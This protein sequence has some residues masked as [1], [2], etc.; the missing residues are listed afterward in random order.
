MTE[1]KNIYEALLAVYNEIGY[2]QKTG[3]N[4]AQNYRF[5][6]EAAFIEALRPVMIMNGIVCH[7]S[8]VRDTSHTVTTKGEAKDGKYSVWSA[9]T[10]VF[11]FHHVSSNTGIDVEVRGEG[12]DFMD[13]ASYKAATGALKY[14]LRQ[15][16]LIETGDDPD[17]DQKDDAPPKPAKSVFDNASLRNK[18]CENV[19]ESFESSKT[20]DELATLATLNATKFADMDA[21][22]NEHDKLAVEELRKRWAQAKSRIDSIKKPTARN[23][24]PSAPLHDDPLNNIPDYRV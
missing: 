13:K 23:P 20:L 10:Y 4:K 24:S 3:T 7:P 16:F 11:H 1:H 9:C 21:S 18:F 5:A 15:T 14:A 22:G 6:G 2:V 12:Q 19:I 8:G 17:N